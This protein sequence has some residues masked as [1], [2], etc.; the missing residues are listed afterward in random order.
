RDRFQWLRDRLKAI[1]SYIKNTIIA[2][3]VNWF[4]DTVRPKINTFTDK[5]KTAFNTLKDNVLDAWQGIKD[6]MKKPINGVI[7][8]YNDHIAGSFNKVIDTLVSKSEAKKYKLPTMAEFHTGGYTGPGAKYKPAGVVHADEYVIRKESQNDLRRNAPGL[9]DSLNRY[10][11]RALGYAS[12][13]LVK[14]GMPF[15]G[16]YPRGDGFGA[17]SGRHKGI[18]WPMPS[19]A[20]LVAVAPGTA[21]RTRNA[22]AGNKLELR[23]GN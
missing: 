5:V 7:G 21:N 23:L 6:G 9:L 2:P 16:S 15:R 10:G 4:D 17:R 8:I 20:A 12:G 3:V 14:F 18:D 22:A 1:W 11:S 13:G 19:G